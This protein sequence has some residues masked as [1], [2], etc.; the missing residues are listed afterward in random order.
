MRPSCARVKRP[1]LALAET[2]AVPGRP[3]GARELPVVV[4]LTDGWPTLVP[5]PVPRRGARR[6][7][8]WRR[9]PA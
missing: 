8:V 7:T 4:L 2:A 3:S 6:D 9:L 1:D 5:T